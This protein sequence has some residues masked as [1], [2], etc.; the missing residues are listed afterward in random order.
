MGRW[1]DV[2]CY[3]NCVN[4]NG[5][6]W[7]VDTTPSTV[8]ATFSGIKKSPQWEESSG[9]P[10]NRSFFIQQD[11]ENPCCWY[12]WHEGTY[13]E[14]TL[15]PTDTTLRML[16]LGLLDEFIG[17]SGKKGSTYFQNILDGSGLDQF[18]EGYAYITW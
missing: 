9:L 4:G 15:Y 3:M 16:A 14:W 1:I 11:N 8:I 7:D 18:M 10:E 13:V 12:W 5:E 6:L 2:P 17:I